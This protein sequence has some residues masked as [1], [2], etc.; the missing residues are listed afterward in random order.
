[1]DRNNAD[2]WPKREVTE[3]LLNTPLSGLELELFLNISDNIGSLY[4]SSIE[5]SVFLKTPSALLSVC[6]AVLELELRSDA[7]EDSD[8]PLFPL[9]IEKNASPDELAG[10]NMFPSFRDV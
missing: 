7:N 6:K 4:M 10:A 5:F 3:S 2:C 1:M 8:E 9:I